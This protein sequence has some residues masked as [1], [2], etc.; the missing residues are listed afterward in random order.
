MPHRNDLVSV[1][2]PVFN[3]SRFIED[4]IRSVLSQD[5][6]KL[7]VIIVD[8]ASMDDTVEKVEALMR[9]DDRIN[10]LSMNKN[11]GVAKTRNKGVENAKGRYIAFLDADDVWLNDKLTKQL[12]LMKNN[13]ASLVY[14]GYEFADSNAV[15]I[16]KS[17]TVP[18]TMELSRLY[19]NHLIWTST[20][21]IDLNVV[22]RADAHMLDI[23][24]GEDI[25]TWWRIVGKYG[26][27][28]GLPDSV[29]LYRRGGNTL[30]SNKLSILGKK[31]DVFK[32]AKLN[33]LQRTYYF[34]AS[35]FNAARKRI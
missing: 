23:E 17:V 9:Q 15:P 34:T 27:A 31:W 10:L 26:V 2:V 3:G 33:F 11:S 4:A 8:D 7:E 20:V 35:L 18:T 25:T 24:F 30:S 13:T 32:Y 6:K 19:G 21:V 22:E 28:H 16:G 12:E 1:I 29:A 5:Y 14:G